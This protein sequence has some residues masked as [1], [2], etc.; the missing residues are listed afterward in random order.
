MSL[1]LNDTWSVGERWKIWAMTTGSAPDSR[2]ASIHQDQ[3]MPNS[4]WPPWTTVAGTISTAPGRI[5][6]EALFLA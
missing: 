2:G 3:L 1:S 5:D 6:V 4:A